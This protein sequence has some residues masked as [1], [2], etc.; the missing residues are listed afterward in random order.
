MAQPLT[1]GIS[2]MQ[3]DQEEEELL[4]IDKDEVEN[5]VVSSSYVQVPTLMRSVPYQNGDFSKENQHLGTVPT[6]RM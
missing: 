1:S 3:E 6:E 4:K 2:W 5:A